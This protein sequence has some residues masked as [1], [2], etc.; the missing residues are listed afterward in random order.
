MEKQEREQI[1]RRIKL[2]EKLG[3]VKFQKVVFQVEKIKFK[4]IKTLCP[5]FLKYYDSYCDYSKKKQL[6]KAKTDRQKKEIIER[7]KFLKDPR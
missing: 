6:E 1:K 3:A 5:N 7:T 2:S 4:V